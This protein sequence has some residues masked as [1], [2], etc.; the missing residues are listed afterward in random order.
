MGGYDGEDEIIDGAMD[1]HAAVAAQLHEYAAS[2]ALGGMAGVHFPHIAAHL[3]RCPVCRASL[4]ELLT[5]AMPAYSGA[6][7]PATRRPRWR[8]AKTASG[9]AAEPW[10][11]DAAGR[12][13]V[14]FSATLLA[15][16]DSV[17]AAA[18]GPG[19]YHYEVQADLVPP[20]RL[21]IEIAPDAADPA[22]SR[23]EVQVDVGTRGSLDQAGTRVVLR[24][25]EREWVL[26]TDPVGSATFEGI[27]GAAVPD[28]RV[29]VTPVE[30]DS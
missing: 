19:R 10:S 5:L 30:G 3:A 7:P 9:A 16:R 6:V 8:V 14:R 25:R 2:L 28:L 11:V 1:P 21:T 15:A 20:V 18:R 13:L 26:E 27:P 22:L 29:E 23:V 17:I 12:L 4:D 24:A